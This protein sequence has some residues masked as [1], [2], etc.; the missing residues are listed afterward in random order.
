VPRPP[1]TTFE[2]FFADAC[3]ALGYDDATYDLL[4]MASREVHAQIPLHRDDGT[5]SVYNGY[6]VQ[7]HNARGAYKGG[8]RYHPDLDLVESRSLACL[9]TFKAALV[10]VPFGGAKGGIDCDPEELS[11]RELEELTRKFVERFHRLIGPNLDVPA[12]DMGTNGQ[13]M[14]WIQD[15]YSK[16]YGYSPA[17][18]TGKPLALGGSKG[19]EAATGTGLVMVLD[20]VLQDRGERLDGCRVA[21]QGLG[22]VGSHTVEELAR[23]GAVVVA[24]SDVHGGLTDDEGLDVDK[25]LASVR[26]GAPL[27]SLPGTVVDNRAVLT[28]D[29][30]VLVPCALGGVVT[31]ELAGALRCRYVVEGAN[32]PVVAAADRV[33]GERGIV[34]V[35]D[36]LANAGGITVSDFEWVQNL[37]QFTWSLDEVQERLGTKM[38]TATRAVLDRAGTDGDTLRRAA[39]RIATERVREAYFLSGF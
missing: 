33:L 23:R 21:V 19:R 14:A 2:T 1:T 15:E 25:L 39:Y 24:V 5:I 17:V 12:P 7:H 6:R 38:T 4:V 16:I 10:D 36:I 20:T 13:I 27:A 11:S 26:D 28:S 22:N 34:V 3:T 31:E 30:D 8:L 37:Q 35:P 29:C 9:M 32:E 18:V